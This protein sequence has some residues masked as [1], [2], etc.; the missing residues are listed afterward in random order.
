MLIY[1]FRTYP[2]IEKLKEIFPNVF[3]F[4]SLKK[5]MKVFEQLILNSREDI[6][7]IAHTNSQSRIETTTVNRFNRGKLEKSGPDELKLYINSQLK[8][9]KLAQR[10]TTAFCN[11]TMYKTQSFIDLHELNNNF[12]F[13]HL[14]PKDISKLSILLDD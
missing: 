13:V 14:N 1:T 9:I 3:V 8:D 6:L 10:P 2:H 12:S 7:G 4:G 5:D 11:W